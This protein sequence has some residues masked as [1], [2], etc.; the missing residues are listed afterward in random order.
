M[1]TASSLGIVTG[2]RNNLPK[3]PTHTQM[4]REANS[5]TVLALQPAITDPMT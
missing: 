4:D 3:I 1:R 2:G 5:Q